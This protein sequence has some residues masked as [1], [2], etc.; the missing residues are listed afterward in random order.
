MVWSEAKRVGLVMEED[1]LFDPVEVSLFSAN[2][3]MASTDKVADLI[4]KF[5]H[6]K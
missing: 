5:R 4:E 3:V 6:G 2:T 1:E